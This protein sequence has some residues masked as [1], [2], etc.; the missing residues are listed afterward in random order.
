MKNCI[1]EKVGDLIAAF[2]AQI[3]D[4]DDRILFEK[5]L[6]VCEFCLDSLVE[7]V[8]I[9][10]DIKNRAG[11]FAEEAGDSFNKFANDVLN[12]GSIEGLLNRTKQEINESADKLYAEWLKFEPLFLGSEIVT[13]LERLLPGSLLDVLDTIFKSIMS[14]WQ[15]AYRNGDYETAIK[16]LSEIND[17]YPD[18]K[19]PK[20][21]LGVCQ[22]LNKQPGEAVK[23]LK[24]ADTSSDS[25]FNEETKW[26]LAQSLVL[27][28]DIEEAKKTLEWLVAQPESTIQ[29]DAKTLLDKLTT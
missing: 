9:I 4:D 24:Q 10:M 16:L 11:V 12:E 18:L 2:E 7:M 22:Y 28:G 29:K 27:N 15:E 20:L 8:P 23:M 3:L 17:K 6:K 26:Y 13:A 14:N 5:H 21:F 19:A 1:D 25:S